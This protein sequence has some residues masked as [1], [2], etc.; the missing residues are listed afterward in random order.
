MENIMKKIAVIT[1]ASSGIGKQFAETL[2]EA[3]NFDEVWVIARRIERLQ[4]LADSMPFP[5]RPIA[6]DLSEKASY[7]TYAALL[8][9]EKPNIGLLI[10]AGGF[11]KFC[12]TTQTPVEVNLNMIDLNCEAVVALCQLSIPYMQKGAH[13]LNIASVAAYQPIPYINVYGATKS[14]VLHFSRALN[15]ELK[16]DGITVTAVCPFWTKTEFFNRSIDKEKDTVV[17]KYVVMYT[18]EQ[19]VSQAWRDM[20]KGKEVSM[21]GFTARTQTLLAKILPHS[22]VMNYWMNQQKLK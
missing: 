4:E 17:K 2:K 18:P 14:F 21:F 9:E 22:F 8:E 12:A 11:G 16:K 20:K 15:R 3:G 10:N 7:K 1:G 13:I 5:T 19:I 6:L